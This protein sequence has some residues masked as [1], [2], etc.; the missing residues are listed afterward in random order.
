MDENRARRLLG[1][2]PDADARHVEGAFRSL[3]RIHHPDRGGDPDHFRELVSARA[4][5][6]DGAGTVPV[7]GAR[8]GVASVIVVPDLSVWQEVWAALKARRQRSDPPRR[9]VE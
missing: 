9:R 3:A 2:A 7:V 8:G 5:L 6:R 1:V 4:A